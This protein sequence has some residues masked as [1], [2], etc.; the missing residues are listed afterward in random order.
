MCFQIGLQFGPERRSFSDKICDIPAVGL[1]AAAVEKT[2]FH[3][4]SLF[5]DQF[6]VTLRQY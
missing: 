5:R 4:N 1:P 3:D 6:A 2:P